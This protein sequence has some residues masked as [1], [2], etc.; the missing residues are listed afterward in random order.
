MKILVVGDYSDCLNYGAMATTD[1]LLKIIKGNLSPSD[2]LRTIE[3]RSFL[4]ATPIDGHKTT[5]EQNL[6]KEKSPRMDGK[7]KKIKKILY[8]MHALDAVTSLS[9]IIGKA[10]IQ[11]FRQPH[12]P[13]TLKEY[14]EWERKYINDEALQYEKQLLAWADIVLINA[15]GSIV[16]GT[17]SRGI[18]RLSALYVLFIA[19]ITKNYEK[20]P[21][22]IINHTVDPHN[23]DAIKIIK[24]VY[25]MVDGIYLRERLSIKLLQQWGIEGAEFVPD[26]LFAYQ[27]DEHW[28]PSEEIKSQVDFSTPYICLGDSS[29]LFASGISIR[30]DIK[31]TYIRLIEE[32]KKICP[33]IVFIDGLNVRSEIIE[34]IVEKEEIG[35]IS[36]L[37]SNYHDLYHILKNSLI[38]ISGRWHTSILALIAK[39]P[40]LLWGSDSHKTEALY[41]LIDYQYEFFDIDA[42]P[43]HIEDIVNEATK[44]IKDSHMKV[45]E[46]VCTYQVDALENCK[47]LRSNHETVR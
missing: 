42:L 8:K 29:G 32:L 31:K 2:E 46:K 30:W 1:C 24:K 40:I 6:A 47:M 44:I 19:Y 22:Y 3:Y 28:E 12:I 5:A 35:R 36:L 9:R 37:N 25:P 23:R 20:K 4:G 26:A 27:P 17:D 33:Q 43:I 34:D 10:N 15:E 45:F 21:C 16:K 38:F 13:I 7:K 11:E 18:Y 14:S 39:T 41:D